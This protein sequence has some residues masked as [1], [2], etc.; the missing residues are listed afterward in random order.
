MMEKA[1]VYEKGVEGKVLEI[2][3]KTPLN[4]NPK[5]SRNNGG[6]KLER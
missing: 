1:W 2:K 3:L 6:A 4:T 5:I